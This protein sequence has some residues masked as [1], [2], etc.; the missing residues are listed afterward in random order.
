MSTDGG[1]VS[2]VL[3][4]QHNSVPLTAELMES[5]EMPVNEIVW[6]RDNA[7]MYVYVHM[8][9]K[10]RKDALEN[11][12]KTLSEK[13]VTGTNIFGYNEIDGTSRASCELIENHPGIKTLVRHEE[14]DKPDFHRWNTDDY[15]LNS[16]YNKLKN[17]LR[18]KS[19]PGPSASG[20]SGGDGGYGGGASND[21]EHTRPSG[22]DRGE[23]KRQRTDGMSDGG[24]DFVSSGSLEAMMEVERAETD[25]KI[26]ELRRELEAL[27]AKY[28]LKVVD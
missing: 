4:L 9:F 28:R 23:S 6:T 14:E 27:G 11:A 17:K 7:V 18:S 20:G 10:T 3:T 21:D 15:G 5:I 1:K 24:P 16:G 25:E 13:G 22:L 19:T 8:L 2:Y 12:M 26:Q